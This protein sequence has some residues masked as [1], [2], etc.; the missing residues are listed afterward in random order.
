MIILQAAAQNFQSYERLEFEYDGLGL[1]LVSGSTGAGKSTLLDLV[2]WCLYGVTSKDGNS[3][4]VRAWD[5]QEATQAT[6]YVAY[7]NESTLAV[8]RIR[9]KGKNDLYWEE[10]PPGGIPSDPVRGKDLNDTQKLLNTRLGVDADLFLLSSYMTQFS[11]ADSFFVASAKDRRKV[12][13]KIADQAFAITLS[14]KTSEARKVSKKLKDSIELERSN[15]DGRCQSLTSSLADMKILSDKWDQ[16]W[17][18][19]IAACEDKLISFDKIQQERSNSW[20]VARDRKVYELK[21]KMLAESPNI[22][23]D[24]AEQKIPLER[25]LF[26]LGEVTCSKCGAQSKSA[27]RQEIQKAL[28]E[29]TFKGAAS[30]SA[31]ARRNQYFDMATAAQNEVN[32]YTY[33][34]ANP[35]GAELEALKVEFN[36]FGTQIEG[37]GAKLKLTS[38]KY[39]ATNSAFLEAEINLSRLNWLYDKSFELR[40]VLM[41]RA[42]TGIQKDTNSYLERFFDA[43]LR[44]TFTLADSDKLEVEILNDGHPCPFTSL[45][46]GERCMLKLAFT[47]S[48]MRAA[49]NKAGISFNVI[50]LDEPFNGLDEGLKEK[51]F[52]LLQELA[53]EYSSVLVIEHSESIKNLFSTR[54]LVDKSGGHSTLRL[55]E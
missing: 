15:L 18:L 13:E 42:V 27:E 50:C 38:A 8:T 28:Q 19:K 22:F 55:D 49:Q 6:V 3:D 25:R 2:P 40:G 23:H 34:Q 41:E 36:P 5:T 24:L 39:V 30:E 53:T 47:L 37:T 21:Q 45:S 54:F 20:V 4:D 7:S 43:A 46:G 10:I 14:E 51:A 11:K 33:S 32:P 16:R 26:G 35:Y 12:L 52:G 31:R 9:G 44:I 1:A 17:A 48:L 29:L